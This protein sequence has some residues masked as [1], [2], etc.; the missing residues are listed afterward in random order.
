[1]GQARCLTHTSLSVSAQRRQQF[2]RR[3][4]PSFCEN[5]LGWLQPDAARVVRAL[6]DGIGSMPSFKVS[7]SEDDISALA[8]YVSKARQAK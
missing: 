4:E 5:S 6:R 1:M 3:L 8:L 2:L 7:L